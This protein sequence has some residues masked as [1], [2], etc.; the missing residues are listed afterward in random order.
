MQIYRTAAEAAQHLG[1]AV[2]TIG[3]FDGIH[4][5]HQAI[6]ARVRELASARNASAVALTFDP[7]PVQFFRPEEAPVRLTPG[8][9]KYEAMSDY[10]L[11]A[12]VAIAFDVALASMTPEEFVDQVLH[13]ALK[14]TVVVVGEGFRFGKRRAGTTEVLAELGARYGFECEVCG[15]IEFEGEVVSSTRVRS[16]V[17]SGDVAR[18]GAMLGRPYRIVGEV[19]HGDARGRELGFPTANVLPKNE[20]LP[21]DGI[22]ATRLHVEG[23]GSFEAVTNV[24]RR[25]TFGGGD[26][27]V[28][29]FV[30]D[31]GQPG[32]FDIYGRVVGV[33]FLEFL[34]DDR[35]FDSAEA[36]IEQMHQ[37]VA[38]ARVFLA[39]GQ[40]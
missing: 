12:V 7:H 8:E 2:I 34:R 31:V 36:L 3:N 39:R 32:G 21:A 29:T 27:L 14:A 1:A 4:I 28:E 11:D 23:M 30:L 26:R 15:P 33:D 18:A 20:A 24:G 38:D 13:Q 35:R 16:A 17:L 5:G 6:F 40:A 10:G 37:D 25:P 22:Y 9:Q 19:I